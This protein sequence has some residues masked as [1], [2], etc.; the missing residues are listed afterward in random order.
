MFWP[1]G[2]WDL[3][4]RT[5]DWTCTPAL[6]GKVLT[7]GPPGKSPL[8]SYSIVLAA[9]EGTGLPLCLPIGALDTRHFYPPMPQALFSLLFQL[10]LLCLAAAAC[11]ASQVSSQISFPLCSTLT[12]RACPCSWL[13]PSL[14][15]IHMMMTLKFEFLAQ[16]SLWVPDACCLIAHLTFLVL[17]VL[18]GDPNWICALSPTYFFLLDF[19]LW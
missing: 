1:L 3:S 18:H 13:L 8:P 2:T 15:T 12:G 14:S 11:A 16:Q 4:S 7:T 9:S 17:R 19:L 5:K 10:I 6:E